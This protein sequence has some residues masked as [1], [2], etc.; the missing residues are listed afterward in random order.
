MY[1]TDILCYGFTLVDY[2]TNEFGQP[3]ERHNLRW[4]RAFGPQP[5]VEFWSDLVT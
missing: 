3:H 4:A 5:T 1:Q 2:F